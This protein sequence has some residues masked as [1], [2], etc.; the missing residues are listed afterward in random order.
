[1]NEEITITEALAEIKLLD[2]KIA[3]KRDFVRD[4]CLYAVHMPDPFERDGGR[5]A[6]INRELQAIGD[7][8]RRQIRLRAGIA[9]INNEEK[10]TIDETTMTIT[11][12]LTWRREIATTE[13]NFYS[14]I[15]SS[16]LSTL[17]QKA[18]RPEARQL[19]ES[20]KFEFVKWD[21]AV[22]ANALRM[23]AE[24]KQTMLDELD[25]KLSMKNA[26]TKFAVV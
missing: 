11:G 20:G 14:S 24:G 10:I 4:N 22:D 16:V 18:E 7:L 9:R 12:W 8:W 15:S 17:K 5:K 3:K 1:M 23:V 25:G 2:K 19:E 13:I 6:V 26:T 21:S